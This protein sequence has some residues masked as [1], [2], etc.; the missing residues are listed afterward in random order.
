MSFLSRSRE[1]NKRR[2]RRSGKS[3]KKV[4]K[5]LR[6]CPLK[7]GS[8]PPPERFQNWQRNARTLDG[9]GLSAPPSVQSLEGL[10]CQPARLSQLLIPAV[11]NRRHGWAVEIGC[12]KR[13]VCC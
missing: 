3:E 10:W 4:V 9:T 11:E 12:V 5:G 1:G 7:E 13:P 2:R 8:F 6:Q